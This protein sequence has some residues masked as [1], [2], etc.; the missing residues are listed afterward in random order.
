M[1]CW[2]FGVKEAVTGKPAGDDLRRRKKSLPVV[3]ALNQVDQPQAARFKEIYSRP[4]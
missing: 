1:I 4:V 2:A 3:Y